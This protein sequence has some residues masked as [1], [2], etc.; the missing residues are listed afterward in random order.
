M[1]APEGAVIRRRLRAERRPWADAI[2][3]AYI[4]EGPNSIA[5]ATNLVLTTREPGSLVEPMLTVSYE[6]AQELMDD[7]WRAGLRPSEGTG[8]AGA[9]AATERHLEDLRAMLKKKGAL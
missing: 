4:E 7:L 3:L 1:E 6:M 9:M 2:E 8:S 5:S